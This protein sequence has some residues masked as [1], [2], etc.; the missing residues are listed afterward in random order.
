VGAGGEGALGVLYCSIVVTS[1]KQGSVLCCRRLH[2]IGGNSPLGWGC[3][4]RGRLLNLCVLHLCVVLLQHGHSRS[5]PTI[6]SHFQDNVIL[7][8]FMTPGLRDYL[9]HPSL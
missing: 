8:R 3:H 9:S 2:A 5:W 1:S 4:A 7:G 6:M